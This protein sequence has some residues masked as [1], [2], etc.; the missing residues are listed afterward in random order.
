MKYKVQNQDSTIIVRVHETTKPYDLT[1][2]QN[3][4]MVAGRVEKKKERKS[5][6]R[7][8]HPHTGGEIRTFDLLV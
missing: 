5:S 1:N 8:E 7:E 4:P 6:L 2:T 3:K